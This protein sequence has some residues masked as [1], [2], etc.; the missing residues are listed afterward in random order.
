MELGREIGRKLRDGVREGERSDPVP[1]QL[2]LEMADLDPVPE[3]DLWEVGGG[4]G[5]KVDD[6]GGGGRGEILSPEN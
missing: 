6:G 1:D 2:W 5:L 4:E 3:P